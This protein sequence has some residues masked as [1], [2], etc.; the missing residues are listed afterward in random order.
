MHISVVGSDSDGVDVGAVEGDTVGNLVGSD[1]G[2]GS[3]VQK[4]TLS[5]D[6]KAA[7]DLITVP[8][9]VTEYDPFP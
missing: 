1:V 2:A 5:L 7:P 4:F 9:S 6:P 3:F 8:S